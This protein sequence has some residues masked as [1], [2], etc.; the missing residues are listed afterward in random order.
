MKYISIIINKDFL[1]QKHIDHNNEWVGEEDQDKQYWVGESTDSFVNEEAYFDRE[2]GNFTIS[3]HTEGCFVSI[4]VSLLT[5]ID[6]MST[7][8]FKHALSKWI[9]SA[10]K[11]QETLEETL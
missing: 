7:D 4:E 2:T 11:A 6:A 1:K 5:W 10:K 9:E 3:V 8:N